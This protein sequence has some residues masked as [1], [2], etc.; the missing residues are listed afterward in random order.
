MELVHREL[1]LGKSRPT[2]FEL[3][4]EKVIFLFDHV[5][6]QR[7]PYVVER[8]VGDLREAIEMAWRDFAF[9]SPLGKPHT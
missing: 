2:G 6:A 3:A 8:P 9:I 1:F 4:E 7:L 5:Q